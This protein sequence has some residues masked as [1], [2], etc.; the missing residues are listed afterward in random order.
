VIAPA[1]RPDVVNRLRAVLLGGAVLC[2]AGAAALAL[3][4]PPAEADPDRKTGDDMDIPLLQENLLK[5]YVTERESAIDVTRLEEWKWAA[6]EF[7]DLG[8]DTLQQLTDTQIEDMKKR[9]K[10]IFH[11]LIME[12]TNAIQVINVVDKVLG[13]DVHLPGEGRAARRILTTVIESFQLPRGTDLRDAIAKLGEVLGCETKAE[14]PPLNNYTVSLLREQCTGEVL[15][16]ALCD[17]HPLTYRIEG[18]TLIFTHSD[19]ADPAESGGEDE[20]DL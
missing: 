16:K 2:A 5:I 9:D 1:T 11:H 13:T 15:I 18:N 10:H 20:E 14:L 6:Q 19:W 3:Q 8:R 12:K 7:G 17:Y 4:D